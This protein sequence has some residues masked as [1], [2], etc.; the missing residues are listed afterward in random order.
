MIATHIKT[1]S[2]WTGDASLYRLNPPIQNKE[3]T[4]EFVVVSAA[5]AFFS[6]PET[7]IFP[8]NESGE[9]KSFSALPGS[10][11]GGLSHTQALE[12]AGYSIK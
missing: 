2:G 9:P 4:H 12:N 7:Y 8:A 3:T 1:L 5:V 10:F 11:K 6:G